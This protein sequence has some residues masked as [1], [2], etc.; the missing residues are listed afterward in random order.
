LKCLICI[1]G[2]L[3]LVA[4]IL[5]VIGA[6]WLIP[7]IMRQ[8]VREKLSG[9]NE[10][11]VSVEH[12]QTSY[13]GRII[14]KGV[15]FY[16]KTQQLWLSAEKMIITLMDWPGLHPEAETV[17]IDGL[18]L[19]LST[20]GGRVV[21]PAVHWSRS[22][23][24]RDEK[25]DLRRLSIDRA[26]VT[27]VNAHGVE[28]AYEGLAL[29]VLRTTNEDYRFVLDRLTAED[30]EVLL[31]GGVVNVQNGQV[32]VS[33]QMRHQFNNIETT[34]VFA[35]LNMPEI[36][37][38]GRLVA[39]LTMT[40]SLNKPLAWR[41]DGSV[42]LRDCVL[43]FHQRMLADDLGLDARLDGQKLDVNEFR[44]IMCGGPIKGD[45]YAQ[46]EDSQLIEYRGR[47]RM[48]DVNYPELTSVL[49]AGAKEAARGTFSGNYDFSGRQNDPNV[50]RGEGLI[51]LKQIDVSI[52]P[53]IPTIFKF[54]GLSS[55]EPLKMSDVEA[56]F[57]NVGP[58]V[59]IDSG[60]ISNLFAAI[61]FEPGG[62]VN[63]QTEQIDGYVVAAPLNKITGVIENLPIIDIFAN[64]KDKLIR[65]RVKGNWSEP[66]SK[67]ISKTPIKDI[68]DSTIGF[69]QDTVKTGGQFGKGMLD[70]LGSLLK[71][72]KNKSE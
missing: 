19:R 15:K 34:A 27:I 65:L 61:E 55:I 26:A 8:K 38:D 71:N 13:T 40:G 2:A 57:Q 29:S 28:V 25:S 31:A 66:P 46:V 35:A 24:D 5:L 3:V 44:A 64:L 59:T 51:F 12:I 68:K 70:L 9:L 56:K 36:S 10:G 22:S 33:L 37:V 6:V 30:S 21:L 60:H 50:L 62:T 20:K 47:V 7:D 18:D 42:D 11:P 23:D 16:D 41:S 4:L 72:N 49:T 14:V 45:F 67:L 32:D 1:I 58:L 43:F 39:N 48:M 52:L 63:L 53:V 54:I 17:Q 69:I